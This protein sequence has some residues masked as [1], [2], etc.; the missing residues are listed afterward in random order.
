MDNIYSCFS[1][2][3]R[4]KSDQPI[5]KNDSHSVPDKSRYTVTTNADPNKSTPITNNYLRTKY[6]LEKLIFSKKTKEICISNKKFEDIVPFSIEDSTVINKLTK[7]VFILHYGIP[8]T[9]QYR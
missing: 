2:L 8:V 7:V 3:Y 4:S 1:F 5:T 6:P 9:V